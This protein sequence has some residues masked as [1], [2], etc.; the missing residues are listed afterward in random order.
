MLARRPSFS[1]LRIAVCAFAATA[2]L[3]TPPLFADNAAS[4]VTE[5]REPRRHHITLDQ[6]PQPD[7]EQSVD[8]Q[9]KILPPPSPAVLH[10]PPGFVVTVFAEEV[11]SARWLALTPTG[12]VLVTQTKGDDIT[13]LRDTDKDG[14]ADF[15]KKFAGKRQGLNLPFGIVFRRNDL[16]IAN[17][18]GVLRFH[19]EEGQ[20]ELTQRGRMIHRLP[21]EGYNQHWTRNLV[22]ALDRDRLFVSVGSK[23]NADI[24]P[25]PRAS[26]LSM[27]LDGR[28][29]YIYASGLRNP[30]G[31]AVHPRTGDLYA[32]VN[33][34][35]KLGNDLVPDYFTKVERGAFYGWPFAYLAPRN[36][37]P[38][39][40]KD[41]Y[42]TNPDLA[43]R[44]VTPDVLIEAHSAALGL[45]FYTGDVFPAPYRFGA[46][47]ALRGS[48]NRET[49]TGFKLIHIP[50]NEDDEP[51]GHYEDFVTGFLTD[52]ATPATWGRPVG[53]M[54]L[55]DGSLL[56]T[57]D[58]NDRVYRIHYDASAANRADT[59]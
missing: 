51:L 23:S 36:L 20:D 35:D 53:L 9:P 42:S 2:S 52:P 48:W 50:F 18:D 27:S 16:F 31:L 21:G 22:L 34:R 43:S 58:A 54:E 8:K 30:V 5:A 1:P 37:D 59:P 7:P 49:G 10:A 4:I 33:E 38:R 11:K 45:T 55:P 28:E 6:L 14:V 19:Y 56:F 47:A 13:L 32:N 46:F 39:Q 17:T 3:S 29:A 15:R 41:G 24:E 40:V 57:D 12:D 44:T 25:L 26:I